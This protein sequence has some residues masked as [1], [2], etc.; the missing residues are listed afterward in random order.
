MANPDQK[1]ILMEQAYKDIKEIC[2]EFQFNSGS[3]DSEVKALLKE[4]AT[5]W[6]TEEENDKLGFH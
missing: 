1:T 6:K 2:Q 5:F 4:L 3:T